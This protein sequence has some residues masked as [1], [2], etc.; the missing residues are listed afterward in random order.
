MTR[1]DAGGS[2]GGS[3]ILGTT[4]DAETGN[5]DLSDG[6]AATV[7]RHSSPAALMKGFSRAIPTARRQGG[8]S[9]A[10]HGI[11]L[12]RNLS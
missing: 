6:T 9:T 4:S 2:C 12:M 3:T 7:T 1:I 11:D 10:V 5:K 8:A